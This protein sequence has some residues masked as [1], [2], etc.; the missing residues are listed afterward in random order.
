[1][2]ME[3]WERCFEWAADV[4]RRAF[5]PRSPTH[6]TPRGHALVTRSPARTYPPPNTP[7]RARCMHT[8][9]WVYAPRQLR[10]PRAS[11]HAAHGLAR[12]PRCALLLVP[13]SPHGVPFA[14][15]APADGR[16]R[17]NS[18][19]RAPGWLVAHGVELS[20]CIH[21]KFHPAQ[22]HLRLRQRHRQ[23]AQVVTPQSGLC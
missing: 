10:S 23:V 6:S 22:N 13:M 11:V 19:L 21:N 9:R 5:L 12:G 15:T 4:V 16:A 14:L 8:P 2:T 17:W 7:P 20:L 18:V 1:M 3:E